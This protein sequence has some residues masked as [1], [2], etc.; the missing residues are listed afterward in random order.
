MTSY[1]GG[2][3][4]G[5]TQAGTLCSDKSFPS[6]RS[7]FPEDRCSCD[8]GPGLQS[9]FASHLPWDW[10]GNYLNSVASRILEGTAQLGQEAEARRR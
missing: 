5:H 8:P 6:S 2:V 4:G 10:K 3:W 9:D 1:E 7:S